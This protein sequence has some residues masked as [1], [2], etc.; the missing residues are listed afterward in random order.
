LEEKLGENAGLLKQAYAVERVRSEARR[1]NYHFIEQK[2]PQG[3]R[4][5]LNV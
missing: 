2:T 3:I 5:T 1:K 4:L